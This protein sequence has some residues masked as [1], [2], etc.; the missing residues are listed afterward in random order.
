VR[1]LA[2][3]GKVGTHATIILIVITTILIAVY[4]NRHRH[5]SPDV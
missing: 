3:E 2:E 4:L 1:E 5:H